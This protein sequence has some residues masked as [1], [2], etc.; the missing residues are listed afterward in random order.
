MNTENQ[1]FKVSL[2]ELKLLLANSYVLAL[3]TQNFHWNVEG[4]YFLML[5]DLFEKQYEQLIEAIDD[6]AE[7][8]R[9]LNAYSPASMAEFLKITTL[10]ESYTPQS[11]QEMIQLLMDD[12]QKIVSTLQKS[13]E[14]LTSSSD[15]G[16]LDFL[17]Q[18]LQAHEKATWIL[19]S[20]IEK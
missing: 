12:H 13:I 20:H 18:R 1:C 19:R 8:I 10:K 6:I 14:N 3:K 11:Y 15:Q 5:H 7:R 17:I 9:T 4:A 16:T 2:K